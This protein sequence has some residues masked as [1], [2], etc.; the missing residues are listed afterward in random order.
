MSQ[1]SHI[2]GRASTQGN[3]KDSKTDA[4][5]T[6]HC[7]VEQPGGH[8][9]V[10]NVH[11][12]E[13][14]HSHIGP[15]AEARLLYIE[16]SQLSQ[17]I[18]SQTPCVI[19]DVGLGIA[20]NSVGVIGCLRSV[21]SVIREEGGRIKTPQSLPLVTL[22]SFENDL[23][24][25]KLALEHPERFP[26]LQGYEPALKALLAQGHYEEPGLVWRLFVG[27]FQDCLESAEAHP[28]D[29]IFYD[30]YSPK[31]CPALWSVE[32]F[33]RLRLRHCASDQTLLLTYSSATAIRVALCLAGF[34][35]GQGRATSRK[36]E[37]T[38]ASPGLGSL[39]SPLGAEWLAK[40][41]RSSRILPWGIPEGKQPEILERIRKAPQFRE[42]HHP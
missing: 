8:F 42:L 34:Q 24:G 9:T 32:L 37:T 16:Q 41:S 39:S 18:R 40:L 26:L 38:V 19:Y 20:A 11:L 2:G 31:T 10:M 27:D 6:G 3:T 21:I 29:L 22:L 14:M 5:A 1:S 35:I 36:S 30:F 12:G 13:A 28:A 7:L 23:E 17:R 33:E 15:E 25:L 4:S